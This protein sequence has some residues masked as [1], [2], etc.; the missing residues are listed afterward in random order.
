MRNTRGLWASIIFV[1][2]L[3]AGGTAG[4]VGGGLRPVL[5]LDLQGGVAVILSA[6]EGTD[7][8]VMERALENIRNRV[9]AFGVGEPDIFLA[10]T[11]I[12]VQI[13]GQ[14]RSTVERREADRWCLVSED[15]D[16]ERV[17]HG[18]AEADRVV[19][20]ALDALEVQGVPS[21][22]CLVTGDAELGCESSLQAAAAA[23]TQL[24]VAAEVSATPSGSPS[25]T[26]GPAPPPSRFCIT[27]LDGEQF[28]CGEDRAE[29]DAALE[30][31]DTEVRARTWCVVE[32]PPEEPEP[33]PTPTPSPDPDDPDATDGPSPTPTATGSASPSPSP[34][35]TGLAALDRTGAAELPCGLEERAEAET[36]LEGIVASEIT[37]EFCVISSAGEDLGCYLSAGAAERRQQETGQERLLQVIGQT[38]RLEQR[39]VLEEVPPEDPRWQTVPVTCET[40]EQREDP[41]CGPGRLESQEVVYF[42]GDGA[43]LRLGPV[44]LAGNNIASSSATLQGGGTAGV[45]TEWAVQFELDGEGTASFA[46]ATTR[47]VSAPPPQNRIA[48]VVDGVVI[49]DPVVNDP[50]TNGS[51]VISGGFTE[52]D[53]KDLATQLNAGALP[54]E[55]TRESVRTVSPTLGEESLRQ[56]IRAGIVGLLLLFVYLLFYYRLLGIV[57]SVGMA[58][59]AVLAITM[60]SLGGRSFG[61]ALTLAGVAGLVISLGVTADSYIVFFERLKDEVRNGRSPRS[62]VQPA[63]KR[64]F[65]TLIAADIVALLA[66]GVL[67]LTA[68]S[69]VRGFALTLGVATLLDVFVVWFYMRPTAFLAARNKRVVGMRHFGLLS[70]IAAEVPAPDGPIGKGA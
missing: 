57:A 38:A 23:Q 8:E 30:A 70:A 27:D 22:V 28:A 2:L 10:G 68:V 52:Q 7:T 14:T 47:A 20:N 50:I 5:G 49:S 19:R 13:P 63:F 15:D 25:P 16:G 18:C 42:R 33:E 36:A 43:K 51:G 54:V 29:V 66:A 41:E 60:V 45:V 48:I 26:V 4:L 17:S 58:A 24:T 56:G 64:A 34:S 46:D 53:A 37:E 59:W 21:E 40:P 55:L 12:E 11:T 32:P 67:Y 44:V 35:P 3:V 9:D 6:P 61:Y 31:V 62:A 65:R 69:S 39:P 1:A